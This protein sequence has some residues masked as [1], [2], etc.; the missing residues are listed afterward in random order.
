MKREN[1]NNIEN[2]TAHIMLLFCGMYVVCIASSALTAVGQLISVQTKSY[3][4]IK[5]ILYN[6]LLHSCSICNFVCL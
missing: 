3:V 1:N 6:K 4:N 2:K 5:K